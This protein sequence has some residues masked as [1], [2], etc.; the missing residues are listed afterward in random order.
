MIMT[1]MTMYER[2]RNLREDHDL[3]QTQVAKLVNVS[4]P[5]Y[6]RY[7]SGFLDIPSE[8]LI[9][10]AKHYGVSVDYLLGLSD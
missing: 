7:E 5:T 6:S 3:S 8:V 10:L 4:Q 2:I 9:I 1:V